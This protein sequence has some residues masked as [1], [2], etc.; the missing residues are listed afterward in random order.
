MRLKSRIERLERLVRAL[1]C[2][3]CSYSLSDVPPPLPGVVHSEQAGGAILVMA[4]CWKCGT[5][6]NVTGG[7]LRERQIRALFSQTP[8]EDSYCDERAAA[9]VA[10]IV[11]R[12]TL[13]Q[14]RER[15]RE[16][17]QERPAQTW[18]APKTKESRPALSLAARQRVALFNRAQAEAASIHSRLIDRYGQQESKHKTF[19]EIET[20]IF[21]DVSPEAVE[22]DAEYSRLSGA[23]EKA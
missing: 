21:G 16:P 6:F 15:A 4:T 20:L 12:Y 19:A 22:L 2:A 1:R 5:R 9:V 3:S 18:H 13:A 11:R 14:L 7:S 17:E 8:P 10:Y 23:E